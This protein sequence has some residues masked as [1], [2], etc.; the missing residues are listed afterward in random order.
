M[1]KPPDIE[2]WDVFRSDFSP[3]KTGLLEADTEE[4][5]I[6]GPLL[7]DLWLDGD[8]TVRVRRLLPEESC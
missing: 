1:L 3:G 2:N 8:G 4:M 7:G 6:K 5:F